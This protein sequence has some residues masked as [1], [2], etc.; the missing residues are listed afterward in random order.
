MSS[1]NSIPRRK[2]GFSARVLR[3]EDPITN[4]IVVENVSQPT[5]TNSDADVFGSTIVEEKI[6]LA[7]D[8]SEEPEVGS[9]LIP[10][11]E[12]VEANEQHDT[13]PTVSYIVDA[14]SVEVDIEEDKAPELT[15]EELFRQKIS[16]ESLARNQ[17]Q[18]EIS[19]LQQQLSQSVARKQEVEQLMVKEIDSLR[20][21]IKG[22]VAGESSR[23]AQLESL[24]ESFRDIYLSKSVLV[25]SETKILEQMR[26]VR[27]MITEQVILVQLD[28][29]VQKKS[30]LIG[31][32]R[33]ICADIKSCSDEVNA[34][35]SDTKEKIA[36]LQQVLKSFPSLNDEGYASRSYSWEEIEIL[37]RKLILIAEVDLTPPPPMFFTAMI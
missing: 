36:S 15:L 28:A 13:A 33:S 9:I 10:E 5:I 20:T 35:I 6:A 1:D 2:Y 12:I 24:Y 22:E 23:L 21:V 16:Q 19:Q 14:D 27:D 37:Q 4:E 32:E 26:A 3:K 11:V 30:E 34:E 7:P 18:I 31:I 25:D 8:V 29:A 17:R